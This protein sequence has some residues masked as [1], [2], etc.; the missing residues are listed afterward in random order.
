MTTVVLWA[1][2]FQGAAKFYAALLSAEIS[3]QS[4]DFVRIS[5]DQNQILLHSVPEDY[6]E[7]VS[8]PPVIR[9][10]A[11]LKPV[12]Q[13]QSIAAAREAVAGMA[14]QVLSADREQSYAATRYCDGFDPD[15][16]VFQLAEG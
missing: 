1:E 5:S 9:E 8:V 14:G 4:A 10:E 15:G 11:A 13:V 12:Y 6:R 7:G 2:E 16:N 3:D